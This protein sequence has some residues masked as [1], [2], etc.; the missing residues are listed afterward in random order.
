MGFALGGSVFWGIYGPN[1]A[2]PHATQ[3]ADNHATSNEARPQK[4]ESASMFDSSPEAADFWFN[5]FNGTL[6]LGAFLVAIGTAGAIKTGTV[7]EKFADVR[8][9]I[10][11]A[12]TKQ[13]VADSDIAHQETA[14]S[15]E[16][17]AELA[18][19]GGQLRKDAEDAKARTKQAELELERLRQRMSQRHLDSEMFSKLIHDSPKGIVE[20]RYLA[21]NAEAYSLANEVYNSL[22]EASWSAKLPAPVRSPKV[23]PSRDPLHPPIWY[24]GVTVISKKISIQDVPNSSQFEDLPKSSAAGA[25]TRALMHSVGGGVVYAQDDA[26]FAEDKLVVVVAAKP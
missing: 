3:S 26:T 16:R 4:E 1:A 19:Q 22:L 13:A 8:I 24:N 12:A 15:N 25:L 7:K 17:I 10:N 11:E 6:V 18:V 5:F 2:L 14:K 21:D 23:V 20:L 9:S